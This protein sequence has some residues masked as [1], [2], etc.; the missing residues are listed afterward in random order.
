NVGEALAPDRLV[1][2]GEILDL[3][4]L[5]VHV[6]HTPGHSAGSLSLFIPEEGVLLTADAIQPTGGRPLYDDVAAA[7]A[8]AERLID[9]PGVSI[10]LKSHD[11][12][13]YRGDDAAAVL[14]AGRECILRM[15]SAVE[16]ALAQL[17]ADAPRDDLA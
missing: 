15:A 1:E 9:L 10:V 14:R 11:R 3:G 5:N 16:R 6:L 2:E 4:G 8:T 17:G 7:L 12:E 13:P